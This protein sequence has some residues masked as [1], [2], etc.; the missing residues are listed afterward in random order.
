MSIYDIESSDSNVLSIRV[1]A[2]TKVRCLPKQFQDNNYVYQSF[3]ISKN[4]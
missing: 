2:Q 1:H 3:K 4:N